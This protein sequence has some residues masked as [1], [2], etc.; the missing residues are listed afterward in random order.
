M[1]T[2]STVLITGATS[3]LGLAFVQALLRRTEA[4]WH[5]FIASR[6]VLQ[7]ERLAAALNRQAGS[8]AV[9][10]I[11]LDLADLDNVREAGKALRA[12]QL[13]LNA[14]VCNA[15]LQFLTEARTVQGLEAT[16]GINHLG[17]FALFDEIHSL[18]AREAR[19]V[20]VS[21]GTHD[22]KKNTGIPAPRFVDPAFLARPER[23]PNRAFEQ[24]DKSRVVMQRRYST[25]KLC[26]LYFA[27]E[28]DRRIQDGRL[29]VPRSVTVNAFDPGLMPG[30]GLARDYPL[31]LRLM[32]NFILPALRPVLRLSM[33]D[34][35][36][37][38]KTS[39]QALAEMIAGLQ[40]AGVSGRY[41]AGRKVIASSDESYDN[42]KAL[43]LWD[44]SRVLIDELGSRPPMAARKEM[45]AAALHRNGTIAVTI[46][47]LAALGWATPGLAQEQTDSPVGLWRTFGDDNVT[48]RGLVRISEKDGEI[49]G[50]LAGTFIPGEDPK[51]PCVNCPGQ[52]KNKPFL[53]LVFLKGLK[54][55][56][57]E[58]GGGEILDP[59][60]GQVYRALLRIE[61]GGQRLE[62][63]GYVGVSLFGRSQTWERVK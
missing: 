37:A 6:N 38:P 44:A 39:G 16:F 47:M 30:T 11:R 57:N 48:A 10:F 28:L 20:I 54:R 53:G 61:P 52:L 3:G 35:V 7:G 49:I 23:D 26:N 15:G 36:N 60:T 43:R 14:L 55:K 21:S 8:P 56:G 22:P 24:T 34:N 63:R 45:P 32:W 17:H 46:T 41:A 19:V 9:E 33:G 25:S 5:I 4:A 62:V 12:R 13:R 27:Y 58:Y 40:W 42:E 31:P 50:T 2:P 59:E 51:R 29:A 1:T 18:L